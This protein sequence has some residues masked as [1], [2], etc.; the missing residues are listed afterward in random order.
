MLDISISKPLGT[1]DQ[2]IQNHIKME[3]K[4][5]KNLLRL[6]LFSPDT[7]KIDSPKSNLLG[8]FIDFFSDPLL[9]LI[10]RESPYINLPDKFRKM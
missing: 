8:I 4:E 10:Y 6:P 5:R 2:I 9:K 3:N 7:R 1:T